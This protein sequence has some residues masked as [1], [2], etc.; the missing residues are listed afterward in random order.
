MLK[1]LTALLLFTVASTVFAAAPRS[2]VQSYFTSR[3]VYIGVNV[4]GGSTE[5]K[6]L[7]D[8]ID[9]IEFPAAR[10]AT[11]KSVREGGASWGVVLGYNVS[12]NF[13][14]ELQYVK[15]SDVHMT[16]YKMSPYTLKDGVTGMV[17]HTWAYSVSGKFF[18]Q[19]AETHMRAFSAVGVGVVHR[20][21]VL[22]KSNLCVTPYMSAGL[23]YAL[24]HH[25]F[26]ESGFQ[27]YTGFG[28]SE[29]HPVYDFIPFAWDAYFRFTY[30]F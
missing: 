7:V 27:Y 3:S 5:W 28:A 18:A 19:L 25:I 8:S 13:A 4:G 9:P 20:Q 6:Y 16:F 2:S 15:F 10:W 12:K 1:I 17:S 14:V 29:A 24:T 26:L 21:D 30:Q 11:P 22:A 23:N